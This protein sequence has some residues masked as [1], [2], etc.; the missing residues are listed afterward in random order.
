MGLGSEPRDDPV[1]VPRA[2]VM[3]VCPPQDDPVTVE[4]EGDIVVTAVAGLHAIGRVSADGRTQALIEAHTD[5]PTGIARA[6]RF[7]GRDKRVF[8]SR[9]VGS[10]RLFWSKNATSP[11]QT[12]RRSRIAG[13]ACYIG[14]GYG[15]TRMESPCW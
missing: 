5:R 10:L 3:F 9:G 8:V 6:Y 14:H 2:D 15:P 4:V 13:G 7:A 12:R 11:T 1:R